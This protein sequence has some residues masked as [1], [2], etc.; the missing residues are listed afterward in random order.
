MAAGAANLLPP[1]LLDAAVL[2]PTTFYIPPTR[3]RW[4]R[5][6]LWLLLPL[7]PLLL[8]A[9]AILWQSQFVAGRA[10]GL[11]FGEGALEHGL[12]LPSL[13]GSL[14]VEAVRFGHGEDGTPLFR[15]RSA[16]IQ[17]ATLGWLL[18]NAFRG[19]PL[20]GMLD[21]L[22]IV[23]EGVEVAYGLDPALGE[24]APVGLSGAPFETLGCPT[25]V[26]FDAKG[27]AEAGLALED[28]RLEFVFLVEGRRLTTRIQ[29]ELAGS[30][31][32]RRQIQQLLPLAVSLL[33][34]D[35]YPMRTLGENWDLEDLG[36]SRIRIRQCAQRGGLFQFVDAH[37]DAV[38]AE[39]GRRGLAASDAA[40]ATYR[41]MVRDGGSLQLEVRYPQP[42]P[43]DGWFDRPR[44]ASLLALSEASLSREGKTHRF[45]PADP[46]TDGLRGGGIKEVQRLAIDATFWPDPEQALV[47][48]EPERASAPATAAAP[49]EAGVAEA[50]PAPGATPSTPPTP[51]APTSRSTTELIPPPKTVIVGQAPTR[52]LDWEQLESRVGARLRITTRTGSTR[53]VELVD[54]SPEQITVRQRLGGGT[55]E[56]RI[57]RDMFREAAEL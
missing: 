42:A 37:V 35:Q 48:L 22:R 30:A 43:L 56:S 3:P 12:A 23:L 8:T 21:R 40:W 49:R 9:G 28:N 2:T 45:T 19:E 17:G 44:P 36:F 1:V 14:R 52:R 25:A 13:D 6:A 27:L 46:L 29:Y 20:E 18:R 33:V 5:I 4:Q 16:R 54:W 47:L 11:V 15:A 24:L 7:L 50:D 10:L 34:V 51:P 57:R 38:R 53:V 41:L 26:R 55:A 31:R 32:I 39:A